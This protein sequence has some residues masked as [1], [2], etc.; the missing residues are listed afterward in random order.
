LE[1]DATTTQ[2]TRGGSGAKPQRLDYIALRI[3]SYVVEQALQFDRDWQASLIGC[4]LLFATN[5]RLRQSL[6][7][8]FLSI[9]DSIIYA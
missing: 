3:H 8:F 4:F 9:I 6:I 2:A 1:S 7:S 5:A